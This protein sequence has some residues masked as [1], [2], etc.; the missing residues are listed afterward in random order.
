MQHICAGQRLH[1]HRQ[2]EV[3]VRRLH[4]VHTQTVQQHQ[5]LLKRRATD[6]YIVHHTAGPALLDVHRSVGAQAVFDIRVHQLLVLQID[7]DYRPG[8]LPHAHRRHITQH[9]HRL[10]HG[11]LLHWSRLLWLRLRRALRQCTTPAREQANT[12]H[13]N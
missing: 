1:R 9:Y 8:S 2:V 10:A 12:K 6:G 7:G 11:S 5:R 3:E 4:I 13:R